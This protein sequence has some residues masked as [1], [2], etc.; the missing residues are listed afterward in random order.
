MTARLIVTA[1]DFGMS[2]EVNEAVE[3]AHRC[4]ILT[5]ASLVVAGAAA[6]DAIRRAKRMPG[7]GVGLHLAMFGAPAQH[8]GKVQHRLAPDGE[9][10]GESPVSTG[11]AI[12]F[13][14]SARAAA[15]RE[16]E[17]QFRAFGQT[18]LELGYLDGHWHCHQHPTIFNMA[19][20]AGRPL[21]LRAVRI[22][23]E[24][25]GWSH[26]VTGHRRLG[27]RI[28]HAVSHAPLA[29]FMRLR[30]KA[31]G[32][33]TNDHFFAKSDAGSVSGDQLL[34]LVQNLPD[35]VT[36]VGL[37]PSTRQRSGLHSPP[38]DWNSTGELAALTDPR[39]R[40]EIERREILLC[41]WADLL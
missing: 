2:L 26:R 24:G 17:A 12:M 16:I 20:A 41:R 14:P 25:L 9:N 4:G 6:E 5:S 30:A 39:L 18:G 34:G 10:L 32:L 21:G 8:S 40:A 27:T 15:R 38:P 29:G 11:I 35:G 19:I 36:E 13:S 22:P 3:K 33:R 7:L 28:G 23:Y 31:A 1:D 37:H